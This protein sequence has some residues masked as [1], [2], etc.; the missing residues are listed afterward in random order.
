MN[1]ILKQKNN[2]KEFKGSAIRYVNSVTL[3]GEGKS[4]Y[5][6]HQSMRGES[7]HKDH[8][9]R[10]QLPLNVKR[11]LI[12]NLHDLCRENESQDLSL[13]NSWRTQRQAW[14]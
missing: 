6:N 8:L 9:A 2:V 4:G 11:C 14:C 5:K 3:A 13:E 10:C 7:R 12:P 1:C